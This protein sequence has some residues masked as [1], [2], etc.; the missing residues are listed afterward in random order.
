MIRPTKSY[1]HRHKRPNNSVNSSLWIRRGFY[2][3]LQ[4]I[5]CIS[6]CCN[7]NNSFVTFL[8]MPSVS[9]NILSFNVELILE[10]KK[11]L[12]GIRTHYPSFRASEGSSCLRPLGYSDRQ[13]LT[14]PYSKY[15]IC[16]TLAWIQASARRL[17]ATRRRSQIPGMLRTVWKPATIRFRSFHIIHCRR[18][19]QRF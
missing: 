11:K 6:P 4:N 13:L 16:P 12:G 1:V 10:N 3:R 15:S 5:L 17:I 14:L 2:I 8:L 7:A 9:S 18:L 19:Y